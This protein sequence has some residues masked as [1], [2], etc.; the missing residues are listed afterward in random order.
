MWLLFYISRSECLAT[1]FAKIVVKTLQAS[2]LI[3]HKPWALDTQHKNLIIEVV[4]V[5]FFPTPYFSKPRATFGVTA[6]NPAGSDGMKWQSVI[7]ETAWQYLPGTSYLFKISLVCFLTLKGIC[8]RGNIPFF[9]QCILIS[10][11]AFPTRLC[12]FFA[13]SDGSDNS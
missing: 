6:V 9:T 1:P 11:A 2:H 5:V 13:F 7:L 8:D 3:P 12:F 10:V 4:I